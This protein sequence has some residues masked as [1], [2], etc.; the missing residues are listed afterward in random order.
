MSLFTTAVIV[1]V[2]I[3]PSY[4][5]ELSLTITTEC[6]VRN[7]PSTKFSVIRIAKVGEKFSNA[8]LEQDWYKFPLGKSEFGYVSKSV[9]SITTIL[10]QPAKVRADEKDQSW[11]FWVFGGLFLVGF[12]V[13]KGMSSKCS[14]CGK[15]FQNNEIDR[16][17]ISKDGFFKTITR[18]DIKRNSK[19]DIIT[20]TDRDEQIH[21]IKQTDKVV[22]KCNHCSNQWFVKETKE[23]E[24]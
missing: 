5:S 19:G 3:L 21:M 20:T 8:S 13:I 2:L 18:K 16:Q 10:D 7:G 6:N 4:A 1:M 9:A 24:G 22:Y 14:S 23:W 17:V 15:W 12:I 11:K